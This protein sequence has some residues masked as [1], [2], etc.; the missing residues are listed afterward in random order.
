MAKFE[1]KQDGGLSQNEPRKVTVNFF[2]LGTKQHRERQ[3]H[4][5]KPLDDLL[6]VFYRAIE[7]DTGK[8]LSHID[9]KPQFS[10]MF[11]GPGGKS[12]NKN[13]EHPIPGTYV[14]VPDEEKPG[15]GT[16]QKISG[17]KPKK[18]QELLGN[19]LGAGVDQNVF[20]ALVYLQQLCDT[21]CQPDVVNLFGFS[22]GGYSEIILANLIREYF[23]DIVVEINFPL[24][25]DPVPGPFLRRDPR[26]KLLP[27]NTG[28]AFIV[29]QRHE[30]GVLFQSQDQTRLHVANPA[31]AH[32]EYA[33]LYGAHG[34]GMKFSS[35]ETLAVPQLVTGIV[36]ETA[37]K[38]GIRFKE[39]KVPPVAKASQS[40][41]KISYELR[42]VDPWS[43]TDIGRFHA[44]YDM[45]KNAKSYQSQAKTPFKRDFLKN[46][47]DYV[48]DAQFFVAPRHRE[49]FKKLLPK[50]FDYRF[51]KNQ[52]FQ[53]S[54]EQVREEL[55]QFR[56]A[57]PQIFELML[58]D[59]KAMSLIAKAVSISE[60]VESLGER[61]LFDIPKES[62][63]YPHI[64]R[65]RILEDLPLIDANSEVE[66]LQFAINNALNYAKIK[67]SLGKQALI[68]T[69]ATS[70]KTEMNI[71][72]QSKISE[73]EK[74]LQLRRM[75]AHYISEIQKNIGPCKLLA[76]LC[77]IDG[78]LMDQ[79]AAIFDK[80][81]RKEPD[82]S[83]REFSV[84]QGVALRVGAI[85]NHSSEDVKDKQ[86]LFELKK[87]TILFEMHGL[88]NSPV[89]K[90]ILNLVETRSYN[91]ADRQIKKI[92]GYLLR[93]RMRSFFQFL[94]FEFFG[95]RKCQ[96]A[97][98]ITDRKYAVMLNVRD[99]L[100]EL[101]KEFDSPRL[102]S[103][104][105]VLDEASVA[106]KAI[107]Q[108]TRSALGRSESTIMACLVEIEPFMHRGNILSEQGKASDDSAKEKS[109][110]GTD[111][112]IAI[113][114]FRT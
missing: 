103:V 58:G 10:H 80:Y 87:A 45:K 7:D 50:T 63:G 40:N 60:S 89:K 111:Q 6:T 71:V 44:F 38:C 13:T 15:E 22:R 91:L 69:H 73:E 77:S 107:S 47:E 19:A 28:H 90:D 85:L 75:V 110:D 11:D 46:L 26:G 17:T 79:V 57:Y 32:V 106:L 16:K 21:G 29:H 25:G 95:S 94:M 83:P 37:K 51:Q 81:L 52:E 39:E 114:S 112:A 55:E 113:T 20:E 92:D 105:A 72:L 76:Q 31:Q 8:D 64:E 49:L 53:S 96:Q 43:M 93:N 33:T 84:L 27:D 98:E 14:Y 86:V 100:L 23:P 78:I 99:S 4:E 1:Q 104:K 70:L 36:Y 35:K 54:P 18:F 102:T 62:M 97:Q 42:E 34:A 5:G 24:I 41:K 82:I 61:E 48:A 2:F 66:Y 108:E 67:T 74:A 68:E 3:T 56:R 59:L 65:L 12:P 9:G 109:F 88:G 30:D 101:R